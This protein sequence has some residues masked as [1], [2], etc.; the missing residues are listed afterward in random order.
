MSN[1][2]A[3]DLLIKKQLIDDIIAADDGVVKKASAATSKAT[4]TQIR[5]EGF[6]RAIISFDMITNEDLDYF[7]DSELPGVW[8]ELEPDSPPARIIP[9]NDTPNTFSYRA[10]KYVVLVAVITTE[11][12]TKNV[13]HLRTYK[14]DVRQI[15]NDNM[16][17]DIHTAED[18][19]FIAEVDRIVGS[20]VAYASADPATNQ[21]V[22]MTN[23]TFT[24]QNVKAALSFLVERQLPTGVYLV[25]QRTANEFLGWKRDEMGGDLSQD[26]ARK[27]LKALE[28]FEMFGIPF[29]STIKNDLVANGVMY[30]FAPKEFLG[31]ALMLEDIT[32]TIKK[33]YDIIRMRAQEQVGLTI[34]NTLGLQRLDYQMQ[35]ISGS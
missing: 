8:F 26:L 13:N 28:K 9:Y 19:S 35:G 34:G 11:E 30:Q 22:T 29:I 33:E 15:V 5:E 12:A 1:Q 21:R 17:R 14:T 24:R 18:T 23:S 27:G 3:Q 20:A 7:G 31:N 32:V 2:A 10:E 6:Q 4:R 25:N 16:L